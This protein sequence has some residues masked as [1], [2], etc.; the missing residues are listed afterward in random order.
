MITKSW[1]QK[2]LKTK[3]NKQVIKK[4]LIAYL[5]VFLVSVIV[6]KY[7]SGGGKGQLGGHYEISWI[8]LFS[9]IHYLMIAD[10]LICY[11]IFYIF[12]REDKQNMKE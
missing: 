12:Y 10:L 4:I 5:L 7:Y 8:E 11:P 6:M 3:I 1:I 9:K 2:V